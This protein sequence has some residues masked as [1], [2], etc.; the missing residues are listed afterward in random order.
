MLPAHSHEATVTQSLDAVRA[1]LPKCSLRE[2]LWHTPKLHQARC[3]ALSIC[4]THES[5]NP[6]DIMEQRSTIF[7][8]LWR[9]EERLS[10]FT[11]SYATYT[12]STAALSSSLASTRRTVRL[13]GS[14]AWSRYISTEIHCNE[15]ICHRHVVLTKTESRI[16]RAQSEPSEKQSETQLIKWQCWSQAL[17]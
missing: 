14:P 15:R 6:S 4:N 3:F 10:L 9:R 11:V 5:K 1:G 8:V 2:R 12:W 16:A 13:M 7:A 17:W